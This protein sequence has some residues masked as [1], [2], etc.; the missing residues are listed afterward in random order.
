MDLIVKLSGAVQES[1]L[2]TYK[3]YWLQQ[4]ESVNTDLKTDED[5]GIAE[6]QVKAFKQAEDMLAVAR[7]DALKQSTDI[8][9]VFLVID[10]ISAKLRNTRLKLAKQV[11]AE[12]EARKNAIIKSGE[13]AVLEYLAEQHE[14]VKQAVQIDGKVFAEAVKGKRNLESMQ[15]AV[16]EAALEKIKEIASTAELVANNLAIFES[17]AAGHTALFP[18]KNKLVAL[19]EEALV[20][21]IEG[22]IAKAELESKEAEERETER[23]AETERMKVDASKDEPEKAPE[24]TE[25][26]RTVNAEPEPQNRQD[27]FKLTVIIEGDAE[28]A[29]E[30][31]GKVNAVIEAY[32]EVRSIKLRRA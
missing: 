32:G 8:M 3:E 25:T 9:D 4:I 12:K 31:A 22:R 2:D 1:N 16:D 13:D 26:E 30:I 10:E 18:D 27:R 5:F 21:T 6:Q 28:V 29:K 23:R 20:A 17:L 14:A 11:K 19:A 15:K 24:N 7:D